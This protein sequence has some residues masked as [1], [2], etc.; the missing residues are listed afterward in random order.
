MTPEEILALSMRLAPLDENSSYSV[1]DNPFADFLPTA[2]PS[3]PPVDYA[4][5]TDSGLRGTVSQ[6]IFTGGTG[7]QM[8]DD[9]QERANAR[10][11]S[12]L[13]KQRM[14]SNRKLLERKSELIQQGLL[15]GTIPQDQGPVLAQQL[16]Q[17]SQ[18]LL[19]PSIFYMTEANEDSPE[20]IRAKRKEQFEAVVKSEFGEEFGS[21]SSFVDENTKISDIGTLIKN[22]KS[23]KEPR[24]SG[25]TPGEH[26]RAKRNSL[27]DEIKFLEEQLGEDG[28]LEEGEGPSG[29]SIWGD[30]AAAAEYL[31]KRD[32]ASRSLEQ[33]RNQL[34]NLHEEM[35]GP[36]AA[37]D[38]KELVDTS[39]AAK[40]MKEQATQRVQQSSR[41]AAAKAGLPVALDQDDLNEYRARAKATGQPVKFIFNGRVATANP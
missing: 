2:Q 41:Q 12:D 16:A 22:I 26:L 36:E 33:K 21:L 8:R 9:L 23:A 27:K 20:M 5:E 1:V 34:F 32:D 4:F 13:Q 11:Q 15:N 30:P 37:V 3:I 17:E 31:K 25:L 28:D 35:Y 10:F 38:A 24:G 6:P 40:G 29:S 14:E 19:A 7:N 18:S 39:L